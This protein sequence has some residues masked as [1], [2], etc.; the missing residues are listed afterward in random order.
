MV[1]TTSGLRGTYR[2]VHRDAAGTVLWVATLPNGVTTQGL[3]Y[4]L[5]AGFTGQAQITGW[6][7]GL[8]DNSGFAATPPADTHGSHAGWVEF[9]NV[10]AT[11][12][13]WN[14]GTL[15]G[16]SLPTAAAAV[17]AVSAAGTIRGVFLCDQA[18]TGSTAPTGLLLSTATAGAG[19]AVAAGGTVTVTYLIRGTPGG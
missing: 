19:L 4:L 5:G 15:S 12:P 14:R 7:L 6:R 11:R 17:F 9:T 3:N 13:T 8:I 16:G 2:L 1:G 10:A 18:P